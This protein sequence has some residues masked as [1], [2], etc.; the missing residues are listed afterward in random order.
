MD[1]AS[2]VLGILGVVAW[3]LPLFGYPINIVGLILGILSK[4]K[5][6]SGMATAG[7]ILT[8]IGLVLTIINSVAGAIMYVTR[9]LF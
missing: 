5:K 1:V 9:L 8:I 7:I 4:K 6:M 3:L 2:L